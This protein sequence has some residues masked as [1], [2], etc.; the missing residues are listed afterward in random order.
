MKTLSKIYK[1]LIIGISTCALAG[2]LGQTSMQ[3]E[4]EQISITNADNDGISVSTGHTIPENT[5]SMT[6]TFNNLAADESIDPDSINTGL[7]ILE[8]PGKRGTSY[9]NNL[10]VEQQVSVVP[11]IYVLFV[12]TVIAAHAISISFTPLSQNQ[13]QQLHA[14]YD[15][16]IF[17]E[18]LKTT[19][20]QPILSE[21]FFA[22]IISQNPKMSPVNHATIA[23]SNNKISL[24]FYCNSNTLHSRLSNMN[25]LSESEENDCPEAKTEIGTDST[26]TVTNANT[27]ELIPG[28]T[29]TESL[30]NG[31]IR[32]V[33]RYYRSP[34]ATESTQLSIHSDAIAAQTSN[35]MGTLHINHEV[36]SELIIYVT[37]QPYK[38]D[39]A[40]HAPNHSNIGTDGADYICDNDIDKPLP[41]KTFKAL[42]GSTESNHERYPCM[43]RKSASQ[44][45]I[46]KTCGGLYRKNW[47]LKESQSYYRMNGTTIQF[48]GKT[49]LDAVFTNDFMYPISSTMTPFQYARV[50][51]SN[52]WTPHM[53]YRD[54]IGTIP[55]CSNWHNAT[56]LYYG[57][58]GSSNNAQL[59][60]AL[61]WSQ[62]HFLDTKGQDGCH[63]R[64]QL[65]C[66]EQP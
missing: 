54:Y 21:R 39:F 53:Q 16:G 25:M 48:I 40:V 24:T 56:N 58:L 34:S 61:F 27:G 17:A 11:A 22:E 47:P 28:D 50:G 32:R 7:Q 9:N 35:F 13:E 8:R 44:H 12:A 36:E 19:N 41:G 65:Y 33:T 63:R 4:K 3:M 66:V 26:I 14:G 37:T 6:I 30:G 29:I 2:V 45:R 51:L 55:N 49:N 1:A 59:D 46:V 52:R 43:Y 23:P 20:Q 10:Q 60:E 38:G 64:Y 31:R 18:N 62:T 42:I 5:E 57:S 15:L